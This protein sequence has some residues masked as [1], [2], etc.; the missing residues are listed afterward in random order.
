MEQKWNYRKLERIV[1]LFAL[2]LYILPPF[3]LKICAVLSSAILFSVWTVH[4]LLPASCL[5][6]LVYFIVT[7]SNSYEF[8]LNFI[9]DFMCICE[10]L[11]FWISVRQ[12][13][14]NIFDIRGL[15]WMLTQTSG[16]QYEP[17]SQKKKF[18]NDTWTWHRRK[19]QQ[20]NKT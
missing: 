6:P 14:M 5:A 12:G 18:S 20:I 15:Y 1:L 17:Q 16:S 4:C 9:H 2:I 8:I 13:Q 10:H 7:L 3:M 19:N 11:Q